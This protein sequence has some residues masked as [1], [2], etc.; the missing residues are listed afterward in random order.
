MYSSPKMEY[1]GI[2]LSFMEVNQLHMGLWIFLGL[3][4]AFVALLIIIGIRDWFNLLSW[5]WYGNGKRFT[6]L[7]IIFLVLFISPSI[8]NNF[9]PDYYGLSIWLLIL[10]TAGL[11]IYRFTGKFKDNHDV[12]G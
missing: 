8:V 3:F 5:S 1:N 10:Y 4:L 12:E 11:L 9:A 6:I 7:F 2:K